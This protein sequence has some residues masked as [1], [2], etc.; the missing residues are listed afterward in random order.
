M[1]EDF[2]MVDVDHNFYMVKFDLLQDRETIFCGRYWII[3]DHYL[4]VC[5][6]VT[7][8]LRKSK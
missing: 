1:Q 4:V 5:P 3:F 2:D 6:R 8:Y 7:L